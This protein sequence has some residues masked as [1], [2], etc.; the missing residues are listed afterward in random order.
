[1]AKQPRFFYGWVMLAVAIAMA[2]ATMPTQTVVISLFNESF[3]A[4]L[5][6]DLSRLS[7]AYTVGTILAALP[8]PWVGRMADRYGLRVVTAGVAL[9]CAASLVLLSRAGHIVVLG[10]AF[11]LIRF[12]G[13]GALGLLAGH[14]IAMWFER[15]LGL[16]HSLLAIIGFAGGSALLPGPVAWL[17]TEHG[18]Q[19]AL[20][21]LAGMVLV[22][23]IPAVLIVFRNKP[24]D[25]GQHL[26]GDPVEHP[27][28]EPGTV[29]P[30]ANDPGFTLHAALRTRAFWILVPIMCA[31]GLIGTALLFHMQVMLRSSGLDAT[32]HQ[33]AIV[34]QSWAIAFGIGLLVMGFLADRMLPRR[35]MPFGPFLMLIA[36]VVCLAGPAGWVPPEHVMTTMRVGMAL[37]GV[38]MSVSVAV[39][40]PTIAR[41]F[42]RTHHGAIRG[43]IQMASV[44]ATG[45]GPFLAGAMYELA[46]D[47]FTPI[48]AAFAISGVPLAA[49]SLFLRPPA[50]SLASGESG[51]G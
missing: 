26:D 30:P 17:I 43:A 24:E 42:G 21:A 13:Q 8:L 39:G 2:V 3:R 6:T 27:K 45:V 23:T 36:C 28:V 16:T 46:G 7:L 47:D 5:D 12:L 18:W 33:T 25:I 11:F 34:N 50:P 51:P 44:A 40:N 20:V 38:A 32:E 1:M 10:G 49:A 48:L 22:L 31:N 35:L 14:T 29:P 37:Y 4:A 19:N 15:R 9:A 41:Y